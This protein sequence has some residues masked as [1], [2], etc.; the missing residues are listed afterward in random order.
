MATKRKLDS[1]EIKDFCCYLHNKGY[2][3]KDISLILECSK[4]L[5]YTIMKK[6]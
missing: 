3:Y 6:R 5:V 4:S 1:K 2:S